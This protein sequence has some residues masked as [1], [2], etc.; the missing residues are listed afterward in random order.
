MTEQHSDEA[1]KIATPV[2]VPAQNVVVVP[3]AKPVVEHHPP[4]Q[5]RVWT[6]RLLILALVGGGAGL[7]YWQAHRIAPLPAW[8][9]YGN[10]RLEADPIDIASKFAGRIAELRADEGDKVTAG[11]IVAVMDTRDLAQ[12]LKRD[13]ALVEQ[14][15]RAIDEASASATQA[16]SATK[17]AEQEMSR[18]QKLV[19]SGYATR[20]LL[21]QRQQALAGA[22]AAQDAAEHRISQANQVLSAANHAAELVRVNIADNTLVAP[23]DGRI[24]YRLAAVGEVL[25]VGG[26]VF[27]MLDTSYVYMDIYLSTLQAD[28]VKIAAPA[29]ILLDAYPDRP[30]P[31]K[32]SFLADQAQFTPK[33]VETKSD[34]DR[35]MFRVR[36]KIDPAR[37][38]D[39]ADEVRS[40]LPGLAYVKLDEKQDWPAALKGQNLGKL[41]PDK[42]E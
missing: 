2:A 32:V 38:R 8:I 24:Q 12:N 15:Q 36:V 20:E 37:A 26:K 7:L 4:G 35:M 1:M 11:Q 33:M 13:E 14:A 31:A 30:I 10:G 16:Q 23:R 42:A 28:K 27:T 29:R 9:A 19:K 21:D 6:R 25:A 3:Q 17:L 41:D 22:Q 34:R 18:T 40:G 39:H 5:T